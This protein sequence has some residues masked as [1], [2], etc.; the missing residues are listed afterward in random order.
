MGAAPAQ[1]LAVAVRAQMPTAPDWNE[2]RIGICSTVK[3][4][5]SRAIV[6]VESAG[7]NAALAGSKNGENGGTGWNED[8]PEKR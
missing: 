8:T 3:V 6:C 5:D 2:G 1:S 7:G 4:R